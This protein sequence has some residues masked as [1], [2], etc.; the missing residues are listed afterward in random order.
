[1][2]T[3]EELIELVKL[4]GQLPKSLDPFVM[5][6]ATLSDV[7]D[8]MDPQAIILAGNFNIRNKKV[9]GAIEMEVNQR[10]VSL[11]NRFVRVRPT[12]LMDQGMCTD[13]ALAALEKA[14]MDK[15]LIGPHTTQEAVA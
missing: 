6:I 15:S 8:L 3:E 14:L 7:V 4:D 12:A 5:W 10:I 2:I 9:I 1:M 11:H 13:A